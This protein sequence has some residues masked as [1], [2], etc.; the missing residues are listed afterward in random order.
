VFKVP[1]Q[2]AG[3]GESRATGLSDIP[4]AASLAGDTGET[5]ETELEFEFN[6]SSSILLLLSIRD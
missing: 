3:R 2:A 6:I 1:L 5:E 4:T